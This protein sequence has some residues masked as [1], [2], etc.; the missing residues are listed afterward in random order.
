[1]RKVTRYHDTFKE[2]VLA[3]ILAPNGPRP[4]ELAKELNI[5]YGTLQTW[6]KMSKK[7][8]IKQMNP[9]NRPKDK[10][11]EAKLQAVI[12]TSGKTEAEIGS[13]CREHGLYANHLEEWKNQ[14]LNGS[15][16]ASI[17]QHKSD[18]QQAINEIKQLKRDLHRKDK[19]L[20]E[21]SALLILKKKADL[22]WGIEEDA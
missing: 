7:Q 14:F 22:L 8:N 11:A 9:P 3:K 4:V 17:K 13:Y 21:V 18:Y 6:I 15:A 20:A 10:S 1:M 5:P 2:S 12:D 16:A 19:A